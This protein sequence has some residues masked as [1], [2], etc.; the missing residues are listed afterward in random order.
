MFFSEHFVTMAA[1]EVC[2]VSSQ[3]SLLHCK[4]IYGVEK[5]SFSLLQLRSTFQWAA[6]ST[7]CSELARAATYG[8]SGGAGMIS[9]SI[10]S[11]F[12]SLNE[13]DR[14]SEVDWVARYQP[15][16]EMIGNWRPW[17]ILPVNSCS[18]L[19]PERVS[20]IHGLYDYLL[21]H[22][23]PYWCP[24]SHMLDFAFASKIKLFIQRVNSGLQRRHAPSK[25]NAMH[26]AIKEGATIGRQKA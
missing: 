8:A 4:S 11:P 13:I 14:W 23:S 17:K 20:C 19:W 16:K 5:T 9:I 10:H 18:L 7:P 12:I 6:S 26:L 1:V 2:S 15:A 22:R 3:L 25:T 21:M 24:C